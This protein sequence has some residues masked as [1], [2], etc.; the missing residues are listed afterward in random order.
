MRRPHLVVRA[1]LVLCFSLLA[2]PAVL[3]AQSD[4]CTMRVFPVKVM[5]ESGKI[6]WGLTTDNFALSGK[7]QHGKPTLVTPDATTGR[8]ILVLD[9]SGSMMDSRDS[10][11]FYIRRAAALVQSLP[12]DMP[13]GLVAFGKT[14]EAQLPISTDRDALMTE[15]E[16]LSNQFGKLPGRAGT[17]L[18]D[19]LR[20][21]LQLFGRIR[22][23]DTIYVIS[24]GVDNTSQ[25]SVSQFVRAAGP[26]RMFAMIPAGSVAGGPTSEERAGPN[27]LVRAVQF[28]GGTSVILQG[29]SAFSLRREKT[30]REL[31]K[32][33]VLPETLTNQTLQILF[34]YLVEFQI[35][36]SNTKNPHWNLEVTGIGEKNPMV[37]YSE[38]GSFCA[39]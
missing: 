26:A 6:I 11:E 1:A 20:N 18:W 4:T 33:H 22:V 31:L 5:T 27:Q 24:D 7:H 34:T 32:S 28:M 14:V 37:L 19:S 17:A 21:S 12:S 38:E 3:T 2:T 9:A 30:E 16:N 13:V 29:S 10:W 8:L 15:L 36:P 23:G 25:T 35:P 39:Q